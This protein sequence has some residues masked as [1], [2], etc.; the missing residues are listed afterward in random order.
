VVDPDARRF[1]WL[2]WEA[3][4]VAAILA[5]AGWLR[6]RDLGIMPFHDDQAVAL[7]IAHDILH[8]DIRTV[9]LTSSSGAANP[10]LYV[11][12][13]ALLVAIHDGAMFATVSVAVLS[14]VAIAL[15]YVAVRPRFG[16]TVA[17]TTAALFATAP[18][19]VFFGRFLWQQ[20][21]LPIATVSLLWTMFVVLERDRTRVALLIPVLFVVA[22]SLNLSAV[23]LILPI[24]ALLVY[25]KRDVDWRAVV[26]GVGIGIVVLAPWLAHNAKHG[27]RDFGLVVNNGRGHGGTPGV[28][29]IEAVRWTVD[30]MSAGGWTFLTGA[31]H[32]G[33]LPWALGRAAGIVVIALLVVGIVT[34]LARVVRDGRHPKADTVRRVLLLIWL[35][36]ICLAYVTS[37]RS[38]VGPHYLLVSYPTSFLLAALGLHDSSSLLLRRR[39]AVVSLATAGAVTAAF[40][41][42]TLSFQAFARQHGGAAGAYW[43]IYDDTAALAKAARARD[44]HIASAPAEYLAWRHLQAPE[45]TTRLVTIR[46]RLTDNSP[47]P[48]TG[49]KRWFGPVEA[50]F[51]R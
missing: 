32:E 14:V 8:G 4:A 6:L 24:G 46:I 45:G 30:L 22:I 40:V 38:G 42:F 33:G 48:C 18:W 3:A 50:C 23:S 37:S 13:V 36:G 19:A 20:N 27:F 16:R 47:L 1:R 15:T 28:G 35:A 2:S 7:R 25:R 51:P 44:L 34:S 12:V 43:V 41:A 11:Y 29:T 26:V 5:L 9:G 31:H 10:P 21:F 39:S 17:L 49:Q